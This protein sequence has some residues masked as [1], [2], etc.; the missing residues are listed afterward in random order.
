MTLKTL[1]PCL[2]ALAMCACTDANAMNLTWEKLTPLPPSAGQ[3]KQPGVA[4]PFAGVHGDAL[5]V[6]GGAN[7][8]EKAP[9]EGGAKIWWNDIWVLEGLSGSNP[10][11][12]ADKTFTLPRRL[13]YGISVDTPEGVIFAGGHDAERCY[14]DV[15]LVSWDA[16]ARAVKRTEL[17][18]MPEP[19]SFMAGA[20][21][22]KT[23]YVAGGQ[24]AMKGADAAATTVFWALDFSKR[25]QGGE[26]WEVLPSWP[27]PARVLPVAAAGPAKDGTGQEFFLFSGRLPEAGK[28]T[29]LLS[30]AY[31]FDPATKTW[32]VLPPVSDG[33]RT[34]VCVMAGAAMAAGESEVLIFGGDRGEVFLE[35]EAHDLAI[36]D[37]RTV[38]GSGKPEAERAI[39]ARLAAK[40]NIY[41]AH[42]GFAREVLA[43]DVKKN[44]WRVAGTMPAEVNPQVTT[45][46]VKHGSAIL[47]PSGEIKPGIRT[48]EVVRV[49]LEAE[50]NRE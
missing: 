40:R 17:P 14:A 38:A 31:A 34:G 29:R 25:G 43:F 20:L 4:G 19:L 45:L 8:P 7:F 21:V 50:G 3:T 6:A 32:R 10:R 39:E 48:A 22:G 49:R 23:L 37:L 44:A 5:I 24:K 35:L 26:K 18:P 27:G 9:W 16:K 11:W 28:P 1:T 36:A 13:G 12:V 30:D 15:Y 42:P 2:L 46:A 33:G 47:L 41:A